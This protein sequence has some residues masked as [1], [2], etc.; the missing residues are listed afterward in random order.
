MNNNETTRAPRELGFWM[1]T[2]LVVGNTIGM[3]IFTLPAAVAPLGLNALVGW[4]VTLF[5]F[6]FIARV[7]AGMARAFPQ[8]DGPYGYA[9]RAFGEGT[10]FLVLW[11]YWVATWIT[12]AA[13]AIAVVGYLGRLIPAI[14]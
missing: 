10:A 12:N 4:I 8:D 2:A 11:C 3:G 9:R 1:A 13:I 14:E 6:I 7:F 5:G